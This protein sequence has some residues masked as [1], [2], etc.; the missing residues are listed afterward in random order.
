MMK[1]STII[2]MFLSSM[3]IELK[4]Q[5]VLPLTEAY[6]NLELVNAVTH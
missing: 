1:K 4:A 3:I 2:I 5:T 6:M